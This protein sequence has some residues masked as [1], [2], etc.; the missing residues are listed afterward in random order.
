[1][2]MFNR[3]S[4]RGFLATSA[5][6]AAGLM[7][8]SSASAADDTRVLKLGIVGCGGRGTGALDDSLTANKYVQLVAAADPFPAKAEALRQTLA[9]KHADKVAL[10]DAHIYGGIDGYKRILSDPEIDI[11]LLTSPPGFRLRMILEA[12]QA[13]KHVFAEG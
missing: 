7:V 9:E 6:A 4:R 13:G 3:H 10:D 5:T 2:E 12:V 11:V 8:H 1:M